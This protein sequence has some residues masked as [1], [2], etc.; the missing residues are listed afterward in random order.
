MK[1][2]ELVPGKG[3]R[4][5]EHDIFFGLERS[6]VRK[7]LG[8]PKPQE[9]MWDDEDEYEVEREDWLRLRYLD[10]KLCDIE[11]LG[12]ALAYD[13]VELKHTDIR[14]LKAG[15]N[16]CGIAVDDLTE[17]LSEGRDCVDLQIVV[18]TGDDIGE[19]GGDKIAWVI[20]SRD[21]KVEDNK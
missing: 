15:L 14:T 16:N 10:N 4:H 8:K 12:G 19:P 9:G 3:I 7:V 21:F 6:A 2:C 5:G 11:V 13:G 18:A 1:H 17:W 20:T